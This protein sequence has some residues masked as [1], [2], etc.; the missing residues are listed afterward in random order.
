[1]GEDERARMLADAAVHTALPFIRHEIAKALRE[2]RE[3]VI[4]DYLRRG[5]ET[6]SAFLAGAKAGY[7]LS[8]SLAEGTALE[9]YY[10]QD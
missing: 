7:N 4:E 3:E 1:M 10:P 6:N 9:D 2:E 8:V 5:F